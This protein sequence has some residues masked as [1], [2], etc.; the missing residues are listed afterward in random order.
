MR[1]LLYIYWHHGD[2][3]TVDYW[4]INPFMPRYEKSRR[5]ISHSNLRPGSKEL[6]RNTLGLTS[7]M[8]VAHAPGPSEELSSMF[9]FCF[10]KI[11][12][13]SITAKSG[14]TQ[15][16]ILKIKLVQSLIIVKLL[17]IFGW[18]YEVLITFYTSPAVQMFI[19]LIWFCLINLFFFLTQLKP[20]NLCSKQKQL[21]IIC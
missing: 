2:E 16:N 14:I 8:E 21:F 17:N 5:K 3:S 6:F 7:C 18:Y 20:G 1:L 4:S 15:N 13:L 10:S 19:H 9:K 12:M 11:K